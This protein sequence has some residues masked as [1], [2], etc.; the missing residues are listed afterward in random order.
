MLDVLKVNTAELEVGMY[1]SSLD[2][3]WLDSPF[4]LQGFRIESED[5]I[6]R[7][8]KYCQYVYVDSQR[9]AQERAAIARKMAYRPRTSVG[10][11][12]L[13]RK[14]KVYKDSADWSRE[15]PEAE[16]AVEALSEGIDSVFD[17]AATDS[18]K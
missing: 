17:S 9:S 15:Y 2:R 13:D 1:V 7:L 14:L 3:P 10:R 5:D 8:Q 18:A 4:S 12:F 11:I 6:E 16:A